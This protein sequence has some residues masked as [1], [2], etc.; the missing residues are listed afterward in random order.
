MNKI[1]DWTDETL[2]DASVYNNLDIY[3][4]WFL[5]EAYAAEEV[6]IPLVTRA[7][8]IIETNMDYNKVKMNTVMFWNIIN[9]F[10][11]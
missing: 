9:H 8:E 2:L 10:Y 4:Y 11:G 6:K 7:F 5:Q 3:V 1:Y